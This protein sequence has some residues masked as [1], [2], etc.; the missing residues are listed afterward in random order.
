[1]PDEVW[2]KFAE[3]TEGAIR[4]SAPRE[5]S[6][7]ERGSG[8]RVTGEY[9]AGRGAADEPVRWVG[10]CYD[11]PQGRRTW[12]ELSGWA[13]LRYVGQVIV[14]AAVLTVL[15]LT[16]SRRPS[17]PEPGAGRPG[18]VMLQEREGPADAAYVR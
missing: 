18:D 1:M 8:I 6:A 5:P 13:R 4:G 15:L 7:R 9:G 17:E 10:E 12:R 16:V 3:D 14:T 2:R 11:A